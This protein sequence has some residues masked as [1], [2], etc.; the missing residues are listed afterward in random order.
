MQTAPQSTHI[1]KCIFEYGVHLLKIR[2]DYKN[3][4]YYVYDY[5]IDY[6]KIFQVN[7]VH[8]DDI[9]FLCCVELPA[10]MR[11]VS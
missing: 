11:G 6:P 9:S 8:P 2:T 1:S 5:I 4:S 7:F 10:F 3:H